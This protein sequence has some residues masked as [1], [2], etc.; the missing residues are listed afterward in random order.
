MFITLEGGEGAGKTTQSILL[1]ERFR[2]ARYIVRQTREP[3]GTPLAGAIRA[4]LL[5]PDASLTALRGVGLAS[6]DEPIEPMLPTTE[7]LLLSA[8]RAQHVARIR[9]WLA[10]GEVVICDRYTDATRV[11]QGAGRGFALNDITVAERL[12]TGG[13]MPDLTLLFD[14]PVEEGQRR[15]QHARSAGGEWNRIDAE[16]IAFHERVRAAYL[17]LAA[18]EPARWLV[19]DATLP[20]ASLA[21]QVWEAVQARLPETGEAHLP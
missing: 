19:F 2:V 8:A 16:S 7:V 9:K 6:G 3:G 12:A 11:Y 17:A 15:R 5:H 20:P 4:V 1:A 18:T 14:L 13:L 10:T 21:E